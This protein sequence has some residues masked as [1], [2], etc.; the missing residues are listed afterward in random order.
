MRKYAFACNAPRSDKVERL[1]SLFY[2]DVFCKMQTNLQ[3]TI[4]CI[5]NLRITNPCVDRALPLDQRP[6]FSPDLKPR[7][8]CHGRAHAEPETMMRAFV[9]TSTE[10]PP[11]LTELPLPEPAPGEIRVKIHACGL[12]FAD[13]LLTRG[14]YQERPPLPFVLG[15][16]VAGEVDALGE[17]VEGLRPGQRVAAFAAMGG[18]AE[19]GCYPAAGCLPIPDAMSFEHAA[20][21]MVA[22]GTSHVALD[23]RARLQPGE[24]LL[25]LGAAG[26]VGLTAVEIGH[27]MGARVVAVARG[28]DKLRIAQQAG[29]EVL[30]DSDDTDLRT[31]F[32]A[33][34]GVDVV[35]DAVGE[36]AASAALRALRPEG[37]Y[38]VIG[39]AGGQVPQFP[40]NL[41]LVKNIDVIGLYWGG[42]AAFR[43]Q[44]ITDSLRTLMGW[45]ARGQ[46]HPHVSHTLPLSR[47][48]EGMELIRSRKSTGKVVITVQD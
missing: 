29:A 23:H 30:I 9:L 8:R 34:G 19:F 33:L 28:A 35:Y 45:Y 11:A 3:S 31:A 12:N 5:R 18:L 26:G 15:M 43:P 27:R 17:G 7:L 1:P 14:Q 44:V 41:L 6:T 16:E 20:S 32:K 10:I 37:R 39:F 40:A 4:A 36:P 46:L 38:L 13:L 21:F 42:F 24:T 22:Y 48:A 47:A 2:Q 25:V